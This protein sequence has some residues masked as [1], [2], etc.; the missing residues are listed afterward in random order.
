MTHKH[1][2]THK[3]RGTHKHIHTHTST[4]TNTYTGRL[5]SVCMTIMV[6]IMQPVFI[7]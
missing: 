6:A 7:P 1:A 3:H 2:Y 5:I 4:H